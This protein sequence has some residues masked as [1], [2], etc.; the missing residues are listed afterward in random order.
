MPVK[1]S[2]ITVI[3]GGTGTA[4]VL[5]A[6]AG[7]EFWDL[8][9]VVAV[10]DSGGSTGRLRDEFGFIP[11]GDIRQCLAA[12][13]VGDTSEQVKQLL[14]YRFTK[15][16]GLA[17]HNLGNLLLT[18]LTDIYQTPG[19]AIEVASQILRINGRVYP[20]SEQPADLVIT[21][22]DGSQVIGEDFLNYKANGGR[23]IQSIALREPTAIYPPA[24]QAIEE[25]D[26]IL[27]G[28]GDLYASLLPN[29]LVAGFQQALARARG[30]FVYLANLMTTFTQT[31]QMTARDHVREVSAYAGRVPD[32][33]IINSQAITDKQLIANYQA[34]GL[35]PLVDDLDESEYQ[36]VR[37]ELVAPVLATRVKGDSLPRS[38][39]RHQS[40]TLA[41]LVEDLVDEEKN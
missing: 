33:V 10:S 39:L 4:T 16:E 14:L 35:A 17:E 38:F 37:A 5:S 36:V 34:E 32:V 2:K 9:A 6:L 28:P 25:A 41:A 31:H 24:A 3:G 11:V 12:L 20:V 22:A 13:A 21:F 1:Q 15:G 19:K 18:A 27:L 30:R 8:T 29:T 23:K 40:E 26:L 7:K